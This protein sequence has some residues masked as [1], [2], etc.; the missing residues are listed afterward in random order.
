M[1]PMESIIAMPRKRIQNRLGRQKF[2]HDHPRHP[3][4]PAAASLALTAEMFILKT[5]DK[6]MLNIMCMSFMLAIALPAGGFYG[7]KIHKN[8]PGGLIG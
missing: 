6:T 5:R 7:F 1:L 2:P 8:K 4:L 3:V